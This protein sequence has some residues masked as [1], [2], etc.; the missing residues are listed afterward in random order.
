MPRERAMCRLYLPGMR[1]GWSPAVGRE[2]QIKIKAD[3]TERLRQLTEGKHWVIVT[4]GVW[5][6]GVLCE[7]TEFVSIELA[8]LDR[9]SAGGWLGRPGGRLQT[10][11][12]TLNVRA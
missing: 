6:P 3:G 4:R 5:L 11:R 12:G 1:W 2:H 7:T 8:E 9:V 10:K